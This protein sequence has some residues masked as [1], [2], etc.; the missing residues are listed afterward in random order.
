MRIVITGANSALGRAI[1]RCWPELAAPPD[2]LVAGVRSD[3]AIEEI[4]PLLGEGASVARIS[5]DDPGTLDAALQ[6]ASAVIHVAG[7]L[8]ERPGS[9]HEQANLAT[10]RSVVEAAKRCGVEKF[11]LISA[12]GA[13]ETSS[14]RYYRTKGQA[15]ACVRASGLCYTIL[16]APLL[17]GPATEGA[18]ALARN[19]S[20]SA[21]R[22]IGGGRNF[23][24]PLYVDDLARAALA[25]ATPSVACNRTLDLVGP[26]SLPDRELVERAARILGHEVRIGSISK[27]LLWSALAVRQRF[28]RPGFSTHVIE[29]ITADTRM[30]PHPAAAELGIALTGIDEMIQGSLKGASK[31][32]NESSESPGTLPAAGARKAKLWQR[33]L[34]LLITLACFTFL[35]NRLNHAAVAEG[36]G[37]LAYLAKSF[38]NVNWYY[39]LAL[40]IPYC[41]LYLLL[42]S[43]VVWSVIN[44]FNVKIRYSDILPIRASAYILSLVNEQVS[45]GAIAVYL[46]RR[47]GVPGWEVGSSMLVIM[48]CEV[49]SLIL[50]ATLGVLLR[51]DNIQPVF[52][53]IPWIALG[54]T[55]FFV[56]FHL[57]FSGRI[58]AGIAL[59]DRSIFRAFRLASVWQ[60]A[61]VIAMRAPLVIS[62]VVVYT[63]ALRLFG[64]TV[65]FGEMLGYLPV[66]FFG[67]AVPGPMHSVAILFWVL[68]FPDKPGQMSAFGFV[69][70]N[71]FI[72][73]NAAVGVLFLRRAMRELGGG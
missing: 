29:V 40:M 64:G 54:A 46:N 18:A 72:F 31:K 24:Q 1:L 56:L 57:F 43:L 7:I 6:G 65:G 22:L 41:L 3:Q 11:V 38:E 50:W 44:W 2:A 36:S 63:L 20:G 14:N 69:M 67:A 48:L 13:D 42:D 59:R 21:A 5:Y 49:Y 35:Y 33:L 53:I 16:R 66:I 47:N 52:H 4:R 25:A 17:L 9:S 27:P 30:D 8:V 51:W 12:T 23:Q 58:G 71:F 39:W 10:A 37:L 19:A 68:L 55:V 28:A 32:V 62:G 45:K 70:H 15:E 61:A 73:F 26:V 34:P 60:Y